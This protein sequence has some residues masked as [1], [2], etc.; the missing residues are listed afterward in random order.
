MTRRLIYTIGILFLIISL[1]TGIIAYSRGYRLDFRQKKLTTTGILS[2]SSTPDGASVFVDE[3]LVSATNASVT[4]LPGWYQ[5]RISKEGYQ[6][7]EKSIR[8]QGELVSRIEALLI[9]ANPSLRALSVTGIYSP[10]FSSNSSKLAY[11]IPKD[12]STPS[13]LLKS[14]VGIWVLDL[15]SGPLGTKNEPKQI[16]RP[17]IS[18]DWKNAR[19]HWSWDEKKVVAI[20]SKMDRKREVVTSA[21]QFNIDSTD[22]F[23]TDITSSVI[24]LLHEWQ[25]Y[26]TEKQKLQI[27]NLPPAV[28]KILN[29]SVSDIRFSPDEAKIFYLASASASLA[30]IITPPLIGTNPTKE[31]RSIEKGKYYIYDIKE[32]KNY[33]ITDQKAA[34]DSKNLVWYSDSK[35]ILMIDKDTIYI[36]DYDGTNKRVVYTGPFEE[37]FVFP[38]P[39]EH[40]L[41]ILTNLTKLQTLPNLYEID[42]R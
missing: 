25:A 6:P 18:Y 5:V 20:F 11:I 38:K 41:L 23:P 29:H 9:P 32:D 14:K 8:I 15:R 2:A 4:L 10:I 1:A 17:A 26:D 35:H 27:A 22:S 37:S 12:E 28:G 36:I 31:V 42:L 34:P 24:N 39:Q 3:K 21:F 33:F 16:F 13:A 30:Q 19:L 40:K 7:W